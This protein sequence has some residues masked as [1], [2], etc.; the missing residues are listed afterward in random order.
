[1][2]LEG[3]EKIIGLDPNDPL[4]PLVIVLGTSSTLWY[5]N[6]FVLNVILFIY[7]N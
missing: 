6:S 7:L 2:A 4:V 1:M 5:E 3:L